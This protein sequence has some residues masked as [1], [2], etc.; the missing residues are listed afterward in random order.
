MLN[1]LC[2]LSSKEIKREAEEKKKNVWVGKPDQET[3]LKQFKQIVKNKN[4]KTWSKFRM[5]Y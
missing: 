2:T 1:A 5:D 3:F 4:K